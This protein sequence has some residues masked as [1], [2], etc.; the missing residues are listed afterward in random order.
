MQTNIRNYGKTPFTPT[1]PKECLPDTKA[2]GRGTAYLRAIADA[3]GQTIELTDSAP[4]LCIKQ[5]N[6][7]TLRPVKAIRPTYMGFDILFADT[8]KQ[9]RIFSWQLPERE[10]NIL[11]EHIMEHFHPDP[12]KIELEYLKLINA[13][14]I[15]EHGELDESDFEK[16]FNAQKLMATLRL[17]AQAHSTPFPGD[18]LQGSYYHGSHPFTNGIILSRPRWAAEGDTRIHFCAQPYVPYLCRDGALDTSGGPFFAAEREYLTFLG[19]EERLFWCFGHD[20]ACG[21]GGIH[22]PCRTNRW[23]LSEKTNI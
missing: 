13:S 3:I 21:N 9:E 2:Y 15:M 8:G 22:F 11:N 23:L 19:E 20:G 17:G 14:F 5:A 10:V 1:F 4:R 7:V 12:A 16:I 18:T 6:T